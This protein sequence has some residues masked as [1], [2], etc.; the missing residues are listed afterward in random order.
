MLGIEG[1]PH[2]NMSKSK[3]S[4]ILDEMRGEAL[5]MALMCPY[6]PLGTGGEPRLNVSKVK[7]LVH[8][9]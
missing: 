4:F 8:F 3:A 7:S 1:E 2:P 9:R 6:S 5:T